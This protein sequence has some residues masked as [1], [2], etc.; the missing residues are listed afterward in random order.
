[1]TPLKAYLEILTRGGMQ[2]NRRATSPQVSY[3]ALTL[4]LALHL[5]PQCRP[6]TAVLTERGETRV[7]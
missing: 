2:L 1:M 5:A 4:A 7:Q 6:A 3:S